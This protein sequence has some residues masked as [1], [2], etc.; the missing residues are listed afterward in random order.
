MQIDRSGLLQ[1]PPHF[2]QPDRHPSALSAF[3]AAGLPSCTGTTASLP[4]GPNPPPAKPGTRPAAHRRSTPS[5]PPPDPTAPGVLERRSGPSPAHRRAAVPL[6]VEPR[7]Q[8]DQVNRHR[9]QPPQHVQIVPAQMPRSLSGEL[10]IVRTGVQSLAMALP[11]AYY[12][13]RNATE[14]LPLGTSGSNGHLVR[15]HRKMANLD[16]D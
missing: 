3:P 7:L 16:C 13:G 15:P 10:G 6:A 12:E 2:Q 4:V 8:L 1:R 11:L 9:I 5:T 14:S